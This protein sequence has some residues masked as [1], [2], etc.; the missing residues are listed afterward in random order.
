MFIK[1][2]GRGDLIQPQYPINGFQNGAFAGAVAAAVPGIDPVKK[3]EPSRRKRY[4]TFIPE[5][6]KSR[7]L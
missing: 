6:T 5:R 2:F 4:R 7:N 1:E 3:K